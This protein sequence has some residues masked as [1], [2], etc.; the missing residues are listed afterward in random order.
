MEEKFKKRLESALGLL[1]LANILT[2]FGI[3]LFGMEMLQAH[4]TV[5]IETA[6]LG[7]IAVI[8]G[9]LTLMMD[10]RL[11]GLGSVLLGLTV[12]TYSGAYAAADDSVRELLLERMLPLAAATLFPIAGIL[13][14]LTIGIRYRYIRKTFTDEI[15]AEVTGVEVHG[16]ITPGH[17]HRKVTRLTWKYQIN[18]RWMTWTSNIAAAS[19]SRSMGFHGTLR[20]NPQNPQE[21]FDPKMDRAGY[22]ITA[23][24]GSLFLI[25][26]IL[27]IILILV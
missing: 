4:N 18:G 11:R 12:V 22:R 8:L 17:R 10:S 3:G 21:V 20:I 16:S 2:A 24:L 1:L 26:G 9:L 7:S 6:F 13:L 15:P 5:W 23:V 19:E 25:T 27:A 14:F